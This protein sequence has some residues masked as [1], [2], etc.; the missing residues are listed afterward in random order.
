MKTTHSDRN[1]PA[2]VALAFGL[3]LPT[4]LQAFTEVFNTEGT[5]NWVCPAG[6]TS[7][8]VECWGGGGAGGSAFRFSGATG[9]NHAGGGGGGG[10]GYAKTIAVAVTPGQTYT[11][12]IP[13][14]AAN[15]LPAVDGVTVDG[16]DVNFAGDSVTTTAAGGKGGV[17]VSTSDNIPVAGAGG[18]GADSADGVGDVVFSGGDGAQ[19]PPQAA[20][21]GGGGAGDTEDGVDATPATGGAGGADGGGKGGNGVSGNR[22]GFPGSNAGGGGGG[23][24]SQIAGA[25]K[26]GGTGGL[27]QIRLSDGV[28]FVSVKDDNTD[29]LNLISSWTGGI[30]GAADLAI[31]DSTVTTAN[32]TVLGVDLAWAGI[33]IQNPGGLVTIDAGNTL[34]L[35]FA[36]TDIDMSAATADL[37]LNCDLALSGINIWDVSAGRTLTVAGNATGAGPVT[38]QGG[39]TVHVSGTG[40]YSGN[41]TISAGTTAQLGNNDVLPGTFEINGTLDLNTYNENLNGFNGSGIVDTVAG[42]NP[43]LTIGFFGQGGNF[44]GVIQ[45]TAGTLNF[46]K[47]GQGTQTLSGANTFSGTVAV[48]NP[49]TT[50]TL[51]VNNL[52]ALQNVSGITL[53]AGAA[54]SLPLDTTTIA[55]PITLDGGGKIISPDPAANEIDTVTLNGAIGGTGDLVIRNNSTANTRPIVVLGGAGTYDGN[56]SI[57]NNTGTLAV[58]QTVAD[59]LPA[60]TELTIEN[61][62]GGSGRYAE[63]DLNGFDQTLAGLTST[64]AMADRAV[65]ANSSASGS[66]LTINNFDDFTYSGVLGASGYPAGAF[67]P[68]LGG[69]NF[70]LTKNNEGELILSG[71]LAYTGDTVVNDG[72]LVL[73]SINPNNEASTVTISDVAFAILDLNYTGTDYV[74]A[75]V[76]GGVS[77]IDGEYGSTASGADNGG[78]GVGFFDD[79]FFGGGTITVGEPAGYVAWAAGFI[80]LTDT[81]ESLDFDLGGLETGIEYVVGGDPTDGS[82][83]IS[84][85]PTSSVVGTDLVFEFR[86]TP[87][88]NNDPNATIIVEYGSELDDWETAVDGV[89]GVTITENIG[90]YGADDQVVVTLPDTLAVDGKIF[91]RL[92]VVIATP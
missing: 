69:D 76:I 20:G 55:A 13:A 12:T 49:A 84:L 54:L 9:T 16:A 65:I 85:A 66:T 44:T 41:N 88:A 56:T 63:Y 38:M 21:A 24:R 3:L 31:W 2:I 92:D 17:S 70:G 53:E 82:D 79:Y 48:T 91:A 81:D 62:G 23:G 29:N 6:V 75:L 57:S 83:D 45:N 72:F 40:T 61:V 89:D 52:D 37:T 60:T 4:N 30:P 36:E 86:R 58:Q 50:G 18:L 73:N 22:D 14:P 43:T 25:G 87:L 51:V 35:G 10:G 19:R 42:G 28:A 59:A 46:V 64:G 8:T 74:N 15:P 33:E 90:F 77:Q 71:V 11:V 47:Q 68:V 39:G 1:H 7:I 5:V 26:P 27:G 32:T 67:D 78:Q 80:A 34:S